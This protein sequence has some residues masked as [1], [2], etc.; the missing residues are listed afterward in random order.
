M[1][2]LGFSLLHACGVKTF[3]MIHPKLKYVCVIERRNFIIE[4][5]FYWLFDWKTES[6]DLSANLSIWD[7]SQMWMSIIMWLC[8]SR[9]QGVKKKPCPAAR[10]ASWGRKQRSKW[11]SVAGSWGIEG[12]RGGGREGGRGV[13]ECRGEKSVCFNCGSWHG[14]LSFSY[15]LSLSLS[16]SSSTLEDGTLWVNTHFSWRN[17][18]C[19]REEPSS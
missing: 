13:G 19:F 7:M 15:F 18:W 12:A 6:T 16:L 14:S 1:R 5:L 3:T 11:L 10:V 17:C 9:P 2:K 4:K 8:K